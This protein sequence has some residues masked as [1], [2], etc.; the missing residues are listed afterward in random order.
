MTYAE[1]A[2]A[3]QLPD[4]AL[5]PEFRAQSEPQRKTAWTTWAAAH[6]AA[7]RARL[8]RGDEDSIVNFWL[9]GTSFTMLPRAAER[10]LASLGDDKSEELLIGRLDDLVAA[11]AEPADNERVSFV[12]RIVE[13]HGIDVTT[14]D[15]KDRADEWL[16]GL[17]ARAIGEMNRRAAE[18]QAASAKG[19]ARALDTYATMYRERGLS[20]DTSLPVDFA[21]D[22]ALAGLAAAPDAPRPIR[23]VAVIG[24]GLDF[25]DKSEG[26]DLYPPQ[27]IQPFAVIDTLLRL[28]LAEPGALRMTTFDLSPRVNDHLRAAVA[29]AR[30]GKPYVMQLPL[31]RDD[32]S[33]SWLPPFE[34]YWSSFG[35]AI[36][37]PATPVSAPASAGRVDVRAVEIRPDLLA[38]ITP[39]DLDIVVQRVAPLGDNDK[40]D[41][42]VATNVLVYY[43]RFE[44][45]LALA[46][47]SAMLRPGGIVMTNYLMHP[48]PPLEEAAG[49]V[50]ATSW[51]RQ[52]NGDTVFGYRYASARRQ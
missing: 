43:G 6:D 49:L 36:G 4:G 18:A 25:T 38:R 27:T 26:Y 48:A 9:Y 32:P 45:G 51:D 50:S 11:M 47:I 8:A 34:E 39:E 16:V 20:S 10:D 5:P 15:G 14:D 13:R 24:P 7:I 23:N 22:R 42:I 35:A 46:N 44:Q 19:A 30:A 1:A 2:S 37:S 52:N 40:F 3:F 17:R 12:R 21:L 33:H 31:S 28:K 29:A 41:L